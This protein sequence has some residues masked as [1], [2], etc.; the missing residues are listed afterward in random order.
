MAS[1]WFIRN[2]WG[3]QESNSHQLG[4]WSGILSV[5]G[6]SFWYFGAWASY[7]V[8]IYLLYHTVFLLSYHSEN[9]SSALLNLK[10]FFK[11]W[12]MVQKFVIFKFVAQLVRTRVCEW[13]CM[14]SSPQCSK[15]K[16]VGRVI[17]IWNMFSNLISWNHLIG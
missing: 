11:L 14:S 8:G 12:K 15:K 2:G 6:Y 16:K 13:E 5:E 7:L 4:P 10:N 17:I 3:I 1:K 9:L